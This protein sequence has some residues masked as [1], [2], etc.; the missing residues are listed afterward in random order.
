M[1]V[2]KGSKQHHLVVVPHRPY[3]KACMS[4]LGIVLVALGVFVSFKLGEYRAS[5]E[6][7]SLREE[8][9][10]LQFTVVK[11]ESDLKAARQELANLSLGAQVDRQAN[12]DVR[13][14]VIQLRT[15]IAELSE[16]IIFYKGLMAPTAD[17]SGLSIG[18]L[19]LL[20]TG[21]ARH[22]SYKVVLQQ[23][24]T[25]HQLIKG[26]LIF[27]LVGRMNGLAHTLALNE[28]SEQVTY[29]RV[30]LRFKYF[31]TVKGELVLPEGFEPEGVEL[32][33]K[34]TGTKPVTVE[35]KFGWVT[36]ES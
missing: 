28:V 18:A 36:Q 25:N 10:Q 9:D 4:L 23:L 8:R 13:Q 27:T 15:E 21:Q 30:K 11:A 35:K 1:S 5:G 31:Q 2:V 29:D 22:Y 24:A 32:T 7:T 34:T 12:E 14:E 6:A 3:F 20:S 33:V 19:D 16:E 17:K 26:D